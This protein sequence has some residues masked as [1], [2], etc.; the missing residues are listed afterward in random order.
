L[1]QLPGGSPPTVYGFP[2]PTS[3]NNL[4][5]STSHVIFPCAPCRGIAGFLC[6]VGGC[7][8]RGI[9]HRRRIYFSE[10][11]CENQLLMTDLLSSLHPPLSNYNGILRTYR[12]AS[13]KGSFFARILSSSKRSATGLVALVRFSCCLCVQTVIFSCTDVVDCLHPWS[14]TQKGPVLLSVSCV[15]SLFCAPIVCAIT[16]IAVFNLC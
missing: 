12:R 2:R 11:H 14:F 3:H 10:T 15:C 13:R 5:P 4:I 9:G 8:G 16:S 7:W 6:C 1:H